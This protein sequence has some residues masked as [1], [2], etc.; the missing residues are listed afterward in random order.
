MRWTA[1][2]IRPEALIKGL[3]Y[4]VGAAIYLGHGRPNGWVGYYGLRANHFV[5]SDG[6]PSGALFSLCCNTASRRNV[7]LSFAEALVQKGKF[8]S[9]F[10]AVDETAHIDNT[11]LSVRIAS[12]MSDGASTIGAVVRTALAQSLKTGESY[13]IIGDPLAPLT[14][15]KSAIEQAQKMEVFA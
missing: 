7:G 12:A 15:S 8:T 6:S 1:D 14:A 11:R 5:A 4:G 2:A 9:V 13:R 3:N 10:A